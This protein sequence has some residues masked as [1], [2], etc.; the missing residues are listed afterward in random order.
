MN[1][2]RKLPPGVV[3]SDGQLAAVRTRTRQCRIELRLVVLVQVC[4]EKVRCSRGCSI[5]FVR[6]PRQHG[7][8]GVVAEGQDLEDGGL[9]VAAP[10][11][12]KGDSAVHRGLRGHPVTIGISE[13]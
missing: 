7:R 10:A 3:D 6:G 9:G 5:L 4:R 1:T 13:V 12:G 2:I 8:E 11:A